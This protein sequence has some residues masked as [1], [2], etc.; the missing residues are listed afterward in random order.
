VADGIG[1]ADCDGM[2]RAIVATGAIGGS[3]YDWHTTTPDLWP[4]LA[5]LRR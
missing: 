5:V 3:L 2:V 1:A 4:H